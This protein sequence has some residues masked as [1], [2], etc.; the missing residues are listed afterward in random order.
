MIVFGL[1]V[2]SFAQ[3]LSGEWDTNIYLNPQAGGIPDFIDFDTSLTVNYNIGGWDFWSY[4]FIE[5]TFGGATGW[6]EQ[7]FGAAGS[8]GAYTFSA[9]LVF[10]PAV[11]EFDELEV[12]A[13]YTIGGMSFGIEFVLTP[14]DLALELVGTGSTG[15]VDIEATLTFGTPG[16]DACDLD[17]TGAEI[18]VAF[19]FCCADVS[20]T[21]E[22]NCDGFVEACFAV[23]G[24]VIPN[25]PWVTVDAEVCFQTAS[26]TLTLT[27]AFDFGADV[28]FDLYIH[29]YP[30]GETGGMPPADPLMLGDI[31]IEGIGLSC[32]IGG[33]SFAAL[34]Y[35]GPEIY[36]PWWAPGYP[37]ILYG[38]EDYWEAYQIGTTDD[39]CCGP[40]SF[41]ITFFFRENGTHLF[42]V[43]LIVANMEL[44]VAPQFTFG[45][46]LTMDVIAGLTD[47]TITFT[48]TW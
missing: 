31:R 32:E 33:V 46:G 15:L 24:V 27:P 13:A 2:V 23:G 4:T 12:D 34:S 20:A 40:F 38:Y 18:E 25:L 36:G 42:D 43:S 17:W 9:L 3:V 39:A 26:K 44:V 16:N 30:Q 11:P 8:L 29:H 41:D 22:F 5:D 35:W 10:D 45:M 1:G 21:I 48:V 14:G 47:W 19:P 7:E 6:T 37:G 28:C